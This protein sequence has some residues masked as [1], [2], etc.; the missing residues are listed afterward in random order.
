[1]EFKVDDNIVL[2]SF[3]EDDAEDM[4]LLIKIESF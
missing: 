2:K 1:M 4:I 3:T